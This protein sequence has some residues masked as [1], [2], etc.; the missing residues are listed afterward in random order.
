MVKIIE[1]LNE[2]YPKRKYVHRL[3]DGYGLTG[4]NQSRLIILEALNDIEPLSKIAEIKALV[5]LHLSSGAPYK[6]AKIL[7]NAL[8]PEVLEPSEQNLVLLGNAWLEAKE[9][10]L[11]IDPLTRAAS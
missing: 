5:N 7:N 11:A 1:E 9:I 10:N 2:A 4:Q 3:A 6:A 8:N